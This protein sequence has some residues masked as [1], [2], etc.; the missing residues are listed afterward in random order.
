MTTKETK[1]MT[2]SNPIESVSYTPAAQDSRC[3]Y[4]CKVVK[5]G[6][7]LP[8]PADV[9]GANDVPAEYLRQG[10]E[11]ELFEGDWLLEGEEV[12]HRRQRGWTYNLGHVEQGAVVWYSFKHADV[13]AF[14][15][16]LGTIRPILGGSG[17]VAAMIRCI[18]AVRMGYS[19]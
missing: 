16:K 8:L 5:S 7:T 18:H 10:D 19:E 11:I 14:L 2:E 4:W 3:R 13:K 12:S 17:D 6:T 15:R 1:T 9:R